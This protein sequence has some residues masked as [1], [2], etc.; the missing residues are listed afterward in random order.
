M[1]AYY[2]KES[3][4]K[5]NSFFLRPVNGHNLWPRSNYDLIKPPMMQRLPGRPRRQRNGDVDEASSSQ[6]FKFC[7][8][9]I[10][11]KEVHHN[12]RTCKGPLAGRRKQ[13]RGQTTFIRFTIPNMVN[14]LCSY[15]CIPFLILIFF[16]YRMCIYLVLIPSKVKIDVKFGR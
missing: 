10:R 7:G 16:I 5:P 2:S 6:L 11:C 13:T 1:H 8:P 3:L 4:V 15:S 12:S 14:N 9:T